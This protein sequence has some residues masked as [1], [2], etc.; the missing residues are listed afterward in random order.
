MAISFADTWIEKPKQMLA[1]VNLT[2]PKL[3]SSEI[4]TV[5]KE[6]LLKLRFKK[7]DNNPEVILYSERKNVSL[8]DVIKAYYD[9]F[10]SIGKEK[11]YTVLTIIGECKD[12]YITNTNNFVKIDDVKNTEAQFYQNYNKDYKNYVQK[13]GN[14]S[15]DLIDYA[16]SYWN[17]IPQNIRENLIKNGWKIYITDKNLANTYHID[18][19][20]EI[21]GITDYDNKTIFIENRKNAIKTSTVHEVGHAVD[22][23]LNTHSNSKIFNEIYLEEY[24]NFNENGVNVEYAKKDN[25]EYFAEL[26]QQTILH[27][28][29]CKKTT[30]LSFT[31]MNDL[32]KNIS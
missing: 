29:N 2:Q 27:P 21:A 14:I 9:P 13:D 25:V 28:E 1:Y 20:D 5:K 6:K 17:K 10:T 23:L 16:N 3:Y 22:E 15:D 32:I 11:K 18:I 19:Y 8:D 30:P 4:L 31:Y 26:F 24:K 7:D 12:C